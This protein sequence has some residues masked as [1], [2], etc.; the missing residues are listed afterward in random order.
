MLEFEKVVEVKLRTENDYKSGAN[1]FYWIA[2]MSILNEIFLQIQ[3]GW[4]FAIGLGITQLLNAIFRNGVGSII[5]TVIL[6]GLFVLFGKMAHQ[7]RRWAF[8]TG[9]I[10]Y[11]LDGILFI[12]VKDY[13]GLGL[14]VFALFY[15]YRGL[16][17]YNNLIEI[18]NNPVV[19]TNEEGIQL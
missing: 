12:I 15:V 7:G 1:W 10:I 8:I 18:N 17:A 3:S 2:G 9:I 5:A 19:K 16:R 14:H 11:S 13:V 6:S 4:S